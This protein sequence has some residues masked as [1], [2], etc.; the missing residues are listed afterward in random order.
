M[1]LFVKYGLKRKIPIVLK[2]YI[3]LSLF[4]ENLVEDNN[5]AV[6]DGCITKKKI[7]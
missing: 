2:G 1:H 4:T 5:T 3:R 7:K 6:I